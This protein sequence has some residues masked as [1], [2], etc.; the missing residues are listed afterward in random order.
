[1][2]FDLGLKQFLTIPWIP[3][4]C[5]KSPY[6][7]PGV[8]GNDKKEVTNFE[9]IHLTGFNDVLHRKVEIIVRIFS[10]AVVTSNYNAATRAGEGVLMAWRRFSESPMTIRILMIKTSIMLLSSISCL[11]CCEESTSKIVCGL[12]N[13]TICKICSE[14]QRIRR[15]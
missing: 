14:I 3:A 13:P 12:L 8:R 10:L 15:A 9:H 11:Y 2:E 7:C 4:R 5:R 1:M 6:R